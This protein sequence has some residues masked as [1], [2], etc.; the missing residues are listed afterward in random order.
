MRHNRLM[1]VLFFVFVCFPA[2]TVWSDKPP[3][4]DHNT[5]KPASI[6]SGEF[7]IS[8]T[9]RVERVFSYR[10]PD[11]TLQFTN[12]FND[13]PREHVNA[14]ESVSEFPVMCMQYMFQDGRLVMTL[15]D[16]GRRVAMAGVL[17]RD[18]ASRKLAENYIK[19]NIAD[20]K[21]RVRYHP[22]EE[23]AQFL[24]GLF[25]HREGTFINLEMVQKGI[26]EVDLNSIPPHLRDSFSK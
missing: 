18:D 6:L 13:I 16:G 20:K 3:A 21:L 15:N 17:F 8:L 7:S 9:D 11:G 2:G 24:S 25:Y 10:L 23:T 26:G 1:A 12:T 5:R 14:I 22:Q 19:E 4:P